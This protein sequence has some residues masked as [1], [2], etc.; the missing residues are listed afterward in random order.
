MHKAIVKIYAD[1]ALEPE[2]KSPGSP[3]YRGGDVGERKKPQ[4]AGL[5]FETT[6]TGDSLAEVT[7]K[8]TNM[9]EMNLRAEQ[10]TARDIHVRDN[11]ARGL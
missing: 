11:R 7:N 10:V 3:N 8:A 9:L 4:T 1:A 5:I 6:V 2:P